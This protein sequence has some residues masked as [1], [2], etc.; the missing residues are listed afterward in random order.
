MEYAIEHLGCR[1]VVVLGHQKC[2]AVSATLAGGTMPTP[3]LQALVDKIRP[4][5][6]RLKGLVQGETLMS[7]AVEANV[8]HS[9]SD[10]IEE[11]PIVRRDLA[12]AKLS[13]VKAVYNLATG[14]VIRL[15][16]PAPDAGTAS[17]TH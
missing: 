4:G 5:I 3:N 16:L 2:G 7:L 6:E 12:E 1:M 15:G 17:A 13:V 14:E 9:A 8:H 11:S 10:V